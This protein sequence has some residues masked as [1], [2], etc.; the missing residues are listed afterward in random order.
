[1]PTTTAATA[2]TTTQTDDRP[3]PKAVPAARRQ[4]NHTARMTRPPTW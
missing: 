3:E 1:M 2:T 4:P